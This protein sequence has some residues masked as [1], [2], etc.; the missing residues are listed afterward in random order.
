MTTGHLYDPLL[1]DLVRFS[2]TVFDKLKLAL[3]YSM[4]IKVLFIMGESAI[5]FVYMY[6]SLWL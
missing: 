2:R 1:C 5:N 3:M 4:S 6:Q